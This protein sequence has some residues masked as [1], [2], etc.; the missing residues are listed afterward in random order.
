MGS[1]TECTLNKFA[2]DDSLC[3][4]VDTLEGR[5]AIQKDLH[6]LE[7]WARANLTKLNKAKC[8]VL[9][10][11][12]G[13]PKHRYRLGG[14]GIESSPVEKDLGVSVDE[15]LNMSRQHAFHSLYIHIRQELR[16]P[17]IA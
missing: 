17:F 6:R 4:T 16:H 5:N 13:N 2:D 3:G 1:G 12:H 7:R 9:H 14:E 15:K 10:L 11:G 8:K